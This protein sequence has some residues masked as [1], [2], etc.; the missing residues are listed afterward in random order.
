[1][2]LLAFIPFD[3]RHLL[4]VFVAII[5]AFLAGTIFGYFV[6]DDLIGNGSNGG[7]P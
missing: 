2:Q 4:I 6:R 5:V 3:G 1:M 7:R